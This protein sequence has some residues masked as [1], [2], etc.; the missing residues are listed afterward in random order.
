[1]SKYLVFHKNYEKCKET[2]KYGTYIGNKKELA[3]NVPEI[4]KS[5]GLVDKDFRS[6]IINRIDSKN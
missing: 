6:A 4:L 5:M 1:M 3:E 2:G